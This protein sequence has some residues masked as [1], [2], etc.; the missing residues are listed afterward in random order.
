MVEPQTME[1][2]FPKLS[3]TDTRNLHRF[4]SISSRGAEVRTEYCQCFIRSFG[5]LLV[6]LSV[7]Q[8]VREA[9]QNGGSFD[10]NL[11]R[12]LISLIPK[13]DAPVNISKFGPIALSNGAGQ[14]CHQGRGK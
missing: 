13:E 1:W 7:V 2:N 8:F 9:F 4:V 5:E 3:R 12:S 11:N 14:D 10:I 6:H